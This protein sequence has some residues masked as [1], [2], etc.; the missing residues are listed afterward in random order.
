VAESLK[1]EGS[2][3]P[4]L[5]RF[6]EPSSEFDDVLAFW[7]PCETNSFDPPKSDLIDLSERQSPGARSVVSPV[8]TL[9]P[10]GSRE[11][12]KARISA[13]QDDMTHSK[14]AALRF[15]NQKLEEETDRL[16][17]KHDELQQKHLDMKKKLQNVQNGIAHLVALGADWLPFSPAQRTP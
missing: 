16:R 4:L 5:P 6:P 7:G 1:K 14:A 10:S 3:C 2:N 17:R 9:F 8:R 12:E 15:R 11:I 13:L